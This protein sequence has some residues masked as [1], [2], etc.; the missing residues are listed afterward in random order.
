MDMPKSTDFELGKRYSFTTIAPTVLQE[1]YTNVKVVGTVSMEGAL[2]YADIIT[3]HSNVLS[4]SGS[5]SLPDVPNGLTF[6]L[7]TK[8]NSNT[9]IP[10]ALEYI[11]SDVTLVTDFNLTITVKSVNNN[12]INLIRNTLDALGYTGKYTISKVNV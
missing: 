6:I 7:F 9:I 12:D 2:K 11:N 1:A 10:L 4:A 5:T 8:D 3:I